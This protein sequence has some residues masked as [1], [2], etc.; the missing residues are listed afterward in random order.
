[1]SDILI[2]WGK[3]GSGTARKSDST[4]WINFG[5]RRFI[6]DLKLIQVSFMDPSLTP[7]WFGFAFGSIDLGNLV[8]K[9]SFKELGN[10]RVELQIILK[11]R[12]VPDSK[13]LI[14]NFQKKIL[15]LKLISIRVTWPKVPLGFVE[16]KCRIVSDIVL[17]N[18]YLLSFNISIVFL[19]YF[20]I[21]KDSYLCSLDIW[22]G[23]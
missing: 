17:L 8:S 4:K 9:K 5:S 13:G 15:D 1:M 11:L 23:S 18:R 3:I 7:A 12:T 2:L 6:L 22:Y 20:Y 10:S 14:S 16:I 19:T 21:S